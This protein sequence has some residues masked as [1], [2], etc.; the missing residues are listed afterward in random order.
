MHSRGE[1]GSGADFSKGGILCDHFQTTPI[2][3]AEVNTKEKP[4]PPPLHEQNAH[5]EA[6]LG[7]SFYSF[8]LLHYFLLKHIIMNNSIFPRLS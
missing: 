5:T 3:L 6:V 2:S 4:P 8:D 1:N 7:Y